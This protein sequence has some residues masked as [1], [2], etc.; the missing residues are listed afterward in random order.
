MNIKSNHQLWINQYEE[1]QR[2]GLSV[3]SWAIQNNLSATCIVKRIRRLRQ[4]GLIPEARAKTYQ[5]VKSS[6]HSFVVVRQIVWSLN[7]HF[8]WY[9]ICLKII[10]FLHSILF[11]PRFSQF[12]CFDFCHFRLHLNLSFYLF[13]KSSFCLHISFHHFIC[14]GMYR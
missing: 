13:R 10:L 14:I 4:M 5:K 2:S 7:S 6:S 11:D 9:Q 1:I 8:I 3:R 12:I